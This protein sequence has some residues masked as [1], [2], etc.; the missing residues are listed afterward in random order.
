MTGEHVR[1]AAQMQLAI[2][3]LVTAVDD[4][5][6]GHYTVG[7]LGNLADGLDH[8]VAAL[9]NGNARSA[10]NH[11]RP[12]VLDGERVDATSRVGAEIDASAASRRG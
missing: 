7:E 1:L 3:M 2:A 9:R 8:L 5:D 10:A 6:A 12:V 4:V 11:E